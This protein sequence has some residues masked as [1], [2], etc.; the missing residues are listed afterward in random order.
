M[1]FLQPFGTISSSALYKYP[2]CQVV[3]VSNFGILMLLLEGGGGCWIYTS[4]A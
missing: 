3:F 2:P 4:C 1:L